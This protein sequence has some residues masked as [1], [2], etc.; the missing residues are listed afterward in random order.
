MAGAYR[1]DVYIEEH[2]RAVDFMAAM[3]AGLLI[4][5]LLALFPRGSPW[6]G[7][8]FFS[9]TV[10]G[11]MVTEPGGSFLYS[12]GAHMALSVGYAIIIGLV[13]D[14]L[15]RVK[16]VVAGGIVGAALFLVNWAVFRFLVTDG[17]GRES[18]V[19]FAH[20]AFG[21]ITAGAYKGLSKPAVARIPDEGP[22]PVL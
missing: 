4:G 20:I 22:Y 18:V 13:V 3:G 10:M 12:L 16:A 21:L 19:L 5:L 8:T 9:P 11:R 15:R 17:T 14:K 1:G 6:S 7:M 2:R